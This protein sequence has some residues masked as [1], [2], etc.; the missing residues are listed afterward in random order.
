M[1]KALLLLKSLPNCPKGRI[2]E[3]DISGDY[4]HSMTDEEAISGKY[5]F[6]IFTKKEIKENSKWFK[7]IKIIAV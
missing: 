6:Y 2:F 4:F 3:I 5:K 7:K 1:K